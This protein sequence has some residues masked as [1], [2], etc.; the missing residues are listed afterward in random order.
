MKTFLIFLT[1]FYFGSNMGCTTV[2]EFLNPEIHE[3]T[4]KDARSM[5]YLRDIRHHHLILTPSQS[6]Q[7]NKIYGEEIVQKGDEITYFS[8]KRIKPTRIKRFIFLII[9]EGEPGRLGILV[10]TFQGIV[11]NVAVKN[12]PLVDG[13]P[14]IPDEF[15][16]QF[17][18]RTLQ[19]S[20]EVAQDHSE[21]FTLPSKVRPIESHL[22]VSQDISDGIRK[23]LVLA[24][25]LNLK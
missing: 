23:V 14:V 13:K 18:G 22:K 24:K 21:F 12:N 25:V 19:S 1:I 3:I 6:E 9:M 11:D 5:Y 8:A 2:K 7:I 15:L 20:W 4:S 10:G 17:L 16:K